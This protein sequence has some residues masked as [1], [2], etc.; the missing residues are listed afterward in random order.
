[1]LGGD[2]TVTQG[3]ACAG[4]SRACGSMFF[5]RSIQQSFWAADDNWAVSA[6]TYI[7]IQTC[8]PKLNLII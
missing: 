4:G 2:V 5:L 7:C 6:E 1:M 3:E 8:M